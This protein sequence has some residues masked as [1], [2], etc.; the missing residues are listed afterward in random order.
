MHHLCPAGAA[1]DDFSACGAGDDG[2]FLQEHFCVFRF[3]S[4]VMTVFD[5]A[6]CGAD[7][8]G[9]VVRQGPRD[10]RGLLA[11][12]GAGKGLFFGQHLQQKFRW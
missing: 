2:L 4:A 12:G 7:H 6:A 9:L 1:V 10:M 11:A 3:S 8:D 5:F